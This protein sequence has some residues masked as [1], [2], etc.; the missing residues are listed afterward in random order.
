M[1]HLND[2]AKIFAT[3]KHCMK[4]IIL[5][6]PRC[7]VIRSYCQWNITY[8]K[9]DYN[10]CIH[11]TKYIYDPSYRFQCPSGVSQSILHVST[12]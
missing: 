12:T 11:I 6:P 9:L 7:N 1:N 10:I 8:F 3:R 2:R 5:P 4:V